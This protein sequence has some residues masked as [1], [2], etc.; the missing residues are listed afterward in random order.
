MA[1]ASTTSSFSSPEFR[2]K[3]H[4]HLPSSIWRASC[5]A[6]SGLKIG[7]ARSRP[8]AVV[9]RRSGSHSAHWQI[10]GQTAQRSCTAPHIATALGLA[11]HAA[12]TLIR[13]SPPPLRAA[14]PCS[15]ILAHSAP[16]PFWLWGVCM[17]CPSL[18]P[19]CDIAPP[20]L[21]RL[22]LL[23]HPLT[24]KL[25]SSRPVAFPRNPRP[26][27]GRRQTEERTMSEQPP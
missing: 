14:A 25:P 8:R 4:S 2:A 22:A 9:D 26:Y 1:L 7:L 15:N 11:S 21:G 12:T 24:R 5:I 19:R 20:H 10:I 18:I 16:A 23:P 3:H 17:I 13:S 6:S 27:G